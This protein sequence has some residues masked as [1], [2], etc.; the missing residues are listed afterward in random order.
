MRRFKGIVKNNVIVLEEG[1]HLP[2]GAEVVVRLK[3]DP[4]RQARLEKQREAAFRRVLEHPITH[5]VG[6]D[7]IIEEDKRE[8]EERADRWLQ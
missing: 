4:E 8:R 3:H 2:E 1:A 5:P 7:E 6:M